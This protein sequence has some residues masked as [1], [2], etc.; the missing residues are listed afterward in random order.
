MEPKHVSK[1]MNA[2]LAEMFNKWESENT[3]AW[4]NKDIRKSI[5]E[6]RAKHPEL[7]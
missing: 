7:N 5:Q 3:P 1:G 6:W 2:Y 4:Q